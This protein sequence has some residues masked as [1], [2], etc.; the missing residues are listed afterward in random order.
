MRSV[1]AVIA[2]LIVASAVIFG[3]EFLGSEV[4]PL[5]KEA[6]P[7]NIQWIKENIDSIPTGALIM[8]AVAH[9]LGI[10]AGMTVAARIA[11]ITIIPSYIVGIFLLAGTIINLIMIPHPLWFS[12]TDLVGVIIGLGIGKVFSEKQ[13]TQRGTR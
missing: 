10:I 1:L 8:V 6:D 12:V 13:I 2:G 9:L 11:K 4:F 5:P 3:F 7:T